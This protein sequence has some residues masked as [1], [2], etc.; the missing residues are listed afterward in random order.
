MPVPGVGERWVRQ[1]RVRARS[2]PGRTGQVTKPATP[3]DS[4]V[5]TQR[6]RPG[7]AGRGAAR[8]QAAQG[9]GLLSQSDRRTQARG[10]D[11]VEWKPGVT[12]TGRVYGNESV[13]PIPS[14]RGHATE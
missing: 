5:V 11:R 10:G 4:P 7:L 14:A 1:L 8:S 3:G 12:P 13:S 9:P 6:H 2:G